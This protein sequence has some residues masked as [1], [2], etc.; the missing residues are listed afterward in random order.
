MND[1]K[2]SKKQNRP[3]KQGDS[4]FLYRAQS[5]APLGHTI[6]YRLELDEAK[7]AQVIQGRTPLSPVH[8]R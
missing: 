2:L 1:V 4:L 3:L 7:F 5:A 6:M 8:R